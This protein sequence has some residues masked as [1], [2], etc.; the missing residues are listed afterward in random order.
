MKLAFL[1]LG[2]TEINGCRTAQF[3]VL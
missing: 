1:D 3:K 2:K